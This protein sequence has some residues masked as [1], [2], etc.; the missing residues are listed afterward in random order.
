[1]LG[2]RSAGGGGSRRLGLKCNAIV[3][4][5]IEALEDP[6]DLLPQVSSADSQSQHRAV[7]VLPEDDSNGKALQPQGL[8]GVAGLPLRE[9]RLA[10]ERDPVIKQR[11]NQPGG[12]RAIELFQ[13]RSFQTKVL[14]GFFDDV[15]VGRS[16]PVGSPDPKDLKVQWLNL[17]NPITVPHASIPR[18]SFAQEPYMVTLP[19]GRLFMGMRTNRGEAWYT[20]SNDG[21]KHWRTADPMRYLDN[22]EV[23]AQSVSPCPVY[24]LDEKQFIFLFNNNNGFVFGAESRWDVRN[25][26]PAYL[27]RGEFRPKAHQSLWWSAPKKFIDNDAVPWGPEKRG[28]LE[29]AA[30]PSLSRIDGKHILWYPDRKGFL[31]GKEIRSQWLADMKVPR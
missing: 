29:A 2:N 21:G 5:G 15:L 16:Q 7:S 27:A 24:S 30:Y 17:D 11:S 19:D 4:N 10:E 9:P 8:Q 31:L 23:V 20:V 3:S 13:T 26:R 18:A 22:G 12:L 6:K 1:M 28:R 14:L 25:R